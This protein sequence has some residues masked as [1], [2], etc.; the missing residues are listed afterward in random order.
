MSLLRVGCTQ[1]IW[2]GDLLGL[3]MYGAPERVH[4]TSKLQDTVSYVAA[5]VS[6]AAQ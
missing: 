6:A 4:V 5:F 1:V 3:L 2:A